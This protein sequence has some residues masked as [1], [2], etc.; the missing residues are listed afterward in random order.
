MDKEQLDMNNDLEIARIGAALTIIREP[1]P[2]AAGLVAE[3]T[4]YLKRQFAPPPEPTKV[5]QSQGKQY[6]ADKAGNAV[7]RCVRYMPGRNSLKLEDGI[8]CSKQAGHEGPCDFSND[9]K[10]HAEPR[11]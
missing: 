11:V 2:I 7:L 4:S 9:P 3:A 6:V 1:G 8:R 5:E 10:Q